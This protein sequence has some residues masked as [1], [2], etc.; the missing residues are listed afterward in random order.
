MHSYQRPLAHQGSLRSDHLGKAAHVA[1]DNSTGRTGDA[2][3]VQTDSGVVADAIASAAVGPVA[4]NFSAHRVA[5]A[6]P[7]RAIVAVGYRV[8]VTASNF[9]TLWGA[10]MLLPGIAAPASKAPV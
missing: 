9:A 3:S 7:C 6:R 8:R 10:G 1:A 2:L 4:L 5:A